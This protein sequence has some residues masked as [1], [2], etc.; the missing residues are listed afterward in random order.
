MQICIYVYIYDVADLHIINTWLYNDV[1]ELLEIHDP[2][3]SYM[4]DMDSLVNDDLYRYIMV[5][6]NAN[7]YHVARDLPT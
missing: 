5:Y 3:M 6:M 1:Y 2:V 4:Y 7:G